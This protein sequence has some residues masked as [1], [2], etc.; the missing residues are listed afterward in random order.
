MLAEPVNLGPTVNSRVGDTSPALSADGLTL[1]FVSMRPGGLGSHDLW[2]STRTSVEEP[3]GEP[4]NLGSPL[5]SSAGD[6][7]PALSADGRTFLFHSDRP[8]GEGGDN[9]IELFYSPPAQSDLQTLDLEPLV[10]LLHR[11]RNRDQFGDG[12][13]L[14][15][16]RDLRLAVEVGNGLVARRHPLQPG[17]R[18]LFLDQ[19]FQ[20]APQ[21]GLPIGPGQ[22]GGDL[23]DLLLKVAVTDLGPDHPGQWVR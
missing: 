4:V 9:R 10:R 21:G 3:F 2:M 19:P 12:D 13:I 18:G 5:N 6:G 17:G 16:Y 7:G 20:V 23:A 15:I 1:L 14:Q 22:P 11:R 8:G